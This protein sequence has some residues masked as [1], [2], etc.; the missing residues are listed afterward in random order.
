MPMTEK[1]RAAQALFL[2]VLGKWSQAVAD[3]SR[4]CPGH[5]H[6]ALMETMHMIDESLLTVMLASV[7]AIDEEAFCDQFTSIITSMEADLAELAD[8]SFKRE[9]TPKGSLVQKP[10]RA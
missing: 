3:N 9:G 4:C 8:T 7:G 5:F 6:E 1:M 2:V 10:A